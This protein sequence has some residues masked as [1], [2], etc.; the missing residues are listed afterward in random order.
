MKPMGP[1]PA[2]SGQAASSP[3]KT[4]KPASQASKPPVPQASEASQSPVTPRPAQASAPVTRSKVP[5]TPAWVPSDD[6]LLDNIKGLLVGKDL[7][8]IQ[9][10]ELRGELEM[11]LGV[12]KGALN[13]VKGNVDKLAKQAIAEAKAAAPAKEEAPPS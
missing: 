4:P 9:L 8:N 1:T 3:S 6:L 11:C 7:D 10:P 5:K 2:A 13:S 12:A